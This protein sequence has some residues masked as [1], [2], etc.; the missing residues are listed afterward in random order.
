MKCFFSIYQIKNR[1]KLKQN[2]IFTSS[3]DSVNVACAGGREVVVDD[4]VDALEVDATAQQ[5]GADLDKF[6]LKYLYCNCF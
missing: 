1:F 5:L 2:I 4:H 6:N 3:S